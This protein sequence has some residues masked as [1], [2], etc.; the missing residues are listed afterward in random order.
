M[1]PDSVV[2]ATSSGAGLGLGSFTV[3]DVE[4]SGLSP[5]DHR[6]LSVAALAL[7]SDG[8]VVEEF[9]TLVDP[10]CDPGPFHIHGLTRELLS[11]AAQFREIEAELTQLLAGR[12][13]VA[14]NAGFD[15]GFLAGEFGRIGAS[16]P[17][18]HRLC[19]LAL[20][21]RVA[22]P[23]PDCRL[24]TLATYY[25]IRQQR[26]HDAHVT[27][28]GP[29]P[30]TM[31]FARRPAKAPECPEIRRHPTP[32]GCHRLATTKIRRRIVSTTRRKNIITESRGR[33]GCGSG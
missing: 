10:G 16:L 33:A 31:V 29:H 3:V 6:V 19:T 11:G 15:Y 8:A 22:P 26:A 4:T 28:A 25:G 9:H 27:P 17:V 30:H 13:M 5:A 20:A 18:G 2:S 12:V 32:K 7:D 24:A 23:V 1:Q 14:H 21:R